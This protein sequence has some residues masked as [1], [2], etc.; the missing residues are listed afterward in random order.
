VA[1]ARQLDHRKLSRIDRS[2]MLARRR[3]RR[4]KLRR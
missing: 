4:Y 1:D 2:V 3:S